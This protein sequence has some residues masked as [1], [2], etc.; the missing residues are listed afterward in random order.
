MELP[1][2][3]RS[4]LGLGLNF[5]PSPK[6]TLGS[7]GIDLPRF[8][9]DL[10]LYNHF[11]GQSNSDTEITELRPQ[12]TW[13]PSNISAEFKVRI[14]S[15]ENE[16]NKNI[17]QHPVRSNLL[18]LQQA[19]LQFLCS[20]PEIKVWSTDKN[21]GHIVTPTETYINRAYSDHLNDSSTYREI[22]INIAEG[23]ILA[24]KRMV[25]NFVENY[26]TSSQQYGARR[27]TKPTITGR[28]LLESLETTDPFAYFY[29]LAKIHKSPWTT[30]PVTSVAGSL[31]H[32]LGQW[33]DKELQKIIKQLPYVTTSSASLI[34]TLSSHS[35]LPL[36][37]QLF[38]ADARSMYTNI[39]TNHAMQVIKEFL[40][41]PTF[42]QNFPNIDRNALLTALQIL[43]RHSLFKFNNKF[44]LQMTGCAMGTPPAPPYATLYFYLHE[45]SFI[46]LFPS[47]I[48]YTRYLDDIFGIWLPPST[49]LPTTD[50]MWIN[51]KSTFDSFGDL[52]WDFSELSSTVNFLDLTISIS[53]DNHIITDLFEKPLNLHLYLPPASLHPPGVLNGLTKGALHR[54]FTL[55]S[56]P[57]ERSKH[58]TNFLQRLYRRGH[59]PTSIIPLIDHFGIQKTNEIQKQATTIRN[60][61]LH[62]VFIPSPTLQL[63]R[64]IVQKTIIQPPSEPPIHHLCNNLGVKL[65]EFRLIL[66]YHRLPNLKNILSPRKLEFQPTGS[67]ENLD[68]NEQL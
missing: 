66:A 7:T 2:S 24:I 43:M 23:R 10:L 65:R 58:I 59:H 36:N 5:I 49:T 27:T 67:T 60:M 63:V 34:N 4:I 41:E 54:I 3:V 1:I 26:H 46:Q 45:R 11:A 31:L 12:S 56:Q 6:K 42:L 32:G 53:I 22:S 61:Y 9:R 30:R 57:T 51:F 18:P 64:P 48:F 17:R 15:F 37:A 35:P 33:V 13:T 44:Y 40:N 20:H 55:C 16:I 25:K 21:L 8:R 47:C 14:N 62:C 68:S 19:G 29:M 28:F 38:T 50:I 52:R 39:N